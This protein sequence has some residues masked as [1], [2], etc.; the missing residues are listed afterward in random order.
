MT[1]YYYS[2]SL[3]T[4]EH[5]LELVRVF[6]TTRLLQLRD[7][8]RLSLVGCR[9]AVNEAFG[10]FGGIKGLEDVLILEVLEKHHLNKKSDYVKRRITQRR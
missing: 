3:R 5:A 6:E 9:H 2:F 7:H 8:A 1:E 4:C 10:E